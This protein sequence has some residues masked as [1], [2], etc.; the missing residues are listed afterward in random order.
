MVGVAEVVPGLATV[1]GLVQPRLRAALVR[2]AGEG[3]WRTADGQR[4]WRP[5]IDAHRAGVRR[6]A[7][8]PEVLPGLPTIARAERAGHARLSWLRDIRI[9]SEAGGGIEHIRPSGVAGHHVDV[10]AGHDAGPV[11]AA[12]AGAEHAADFEADPEP[13]RVGRIE[14]DRAGAGAGRAVR[15]APFLG[16]GDTL[17]RVDLGP[18]V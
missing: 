7:V 5:G 13:L 14:H 4:V 16:A 17:H 12:V 1:G 2:V 3:G 9:A 11:L 6:L 18:G 8:L 15:H 10:A